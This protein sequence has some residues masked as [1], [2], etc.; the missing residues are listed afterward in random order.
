MG[1]RLS[2]E[3]TLITHIDKGPTP[4]LAHPASPQ[5]GHQQ[6]LRLRLSG[7]EGAARHHGQ[8]EGR[9]LAEHQPAARSPAASAQLDAAGLDRLLQ[10]RVLKRDLRASGH[11]LW[12]QV[13][14]WIGR[15]H[16]RTPWRQLRRRYSKGDGWPARR[17][18]G[19]IQPGRG[20]HRA[21]PLPGRADPQTVAEHSMR[22]AAKYS[23][24][25][26]APGAQ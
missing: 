12:H 22:S 21:L 20:A 3:K 26:G 9:V 11:Y 19:A 15:K 18:G 10:V 13:I 23:G 4:R 24:A 14:R 16:R 1:L 25:C 7:Q 6:T 5:A 8:G 2:P 17:R